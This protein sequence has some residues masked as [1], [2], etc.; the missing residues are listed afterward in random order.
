MHADCA[1]R[2]VIG[3]CSEPGEV[4]QTSV[5]KKI[6]SDLDVASESDFDILLAI[7]EKHA[8]GTYKAVAGDPAI[9]EE[10][11]LELFESF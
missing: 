1:D 10:V 4:L 7:A 2:L 8:P 11:F 3:D 9:I 5:I 6:R